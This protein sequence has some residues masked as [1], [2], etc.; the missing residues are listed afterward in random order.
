MGKKK[1]TN[2]AITVIKKMRK[3]AVNND[4]EKATSEKA[5]S[6]FFSVNSEVNFRRAHRCW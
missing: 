5:L 6:K 4:E 3:N 1:L 2:N